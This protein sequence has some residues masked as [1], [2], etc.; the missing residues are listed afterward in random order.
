M[1]I[2]DRKKEIFKTASGKYI[3]PQLIENKLKES[4][5][6][7]NAMVVGE[8]QKYPAALISLNF[9]HLR[10]WCEIKKVPFTTN[11]DI[12]TNPVIKKRIAKEIDKVNSGLG[13]H[14]RIVKFEFTGNTWSVDTGELTPTLKLRR[15]IISEKY[16]FILSKLF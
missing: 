9:F 15:K 13:E 12:L 6:I 1:K 16:S 5:F 3:S 2:T 10:S 4:P 14:E 11:E 8:N 7:D